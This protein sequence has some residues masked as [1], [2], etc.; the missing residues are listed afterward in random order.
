MLH[1]SGPFQSQNGLILTSLPLTDIVAP[2]TFQSQNGLILTLLYI[3]FNQFILIISIP[4]W[5]DFNALPLSRSAQHIL[6]QSQNGLILTQVLNRA[7]NGRNI[8]Q[9]Q[10]GL[11]LTR[12]RMMCLFASLDFNPKMV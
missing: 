1:L 6:F 11:I 12:A 4:K 5:S 2:S 3:I 8:F 7:T 9:S 10:N